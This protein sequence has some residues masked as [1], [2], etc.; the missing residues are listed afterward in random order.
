MFGNNIKLYAFKSLVSRYWLVFKGAWSVRDKLDPPK[1]N[2]DELAFLPAHLELVET[3]VSAAPKWT[4]RIIITFTVLALVWSI[5][6]QIDVVATGQGKIILS[7][8]S[9][10]IQSLE[11]AV[12][13]SLYVA[14][15]QQ[16]EQGEVLI[17]LAALGSDTDY[18]QAS[19]ALKAAYLTRWRST[20]LISSIKTREVPVHQEITDLFS[21]DINE[22]DIEQNLTLALNQFFSWRTKDHQLALL[23]EQKQAE[24]ETLKLEL[25]KTGNL[26]S[27][28]NKKLDNLYDLHKNSYISEHAYLEQR[29]IVINL[30]SDKETYLS[31][32]NEI[33]KSI[34]QTEEERQLNTQNLI[35]ESLDN[36]RQAN[37][38]IS[39]LASETSKAKQR[40]QL[41]KLV[42]PVDGTVQQLD[43][44]T[45]GGVVTTAQ[46]LMVVVPMQDKFEVE[47][48]IQNKDIGFIKPGQ[49][50]VIKIESFPYTRYGYIT[51]KVRS[52]SFDAI[53][54]PD[55]GLIF[56]AIVTL[57]KDHLKIE[58]NTVQLTAGMSV[59]VEINTD[60]RKIIDYLLSPLKTKID[61]SFKER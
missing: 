55:L 9:K 61:S 54:D 22:V 5:V 15:G 7:G 12:V 18:E 46:P 37:E 59:S 30:K 56:S 43:V 13:K 38:Q 33:K 32:I 17:E 27:I 48:M 29:S 23:V 35:T 1:R 39:Q 8:H 28:E 24:I 41:M 20:Q 50:A 2:S 58:N 19:Q 47:T 16:V 42:S 49:T 51:G 52:V 34:S 36:L 53:E 6:G 3:P 57:D 21:K 14:N 4:A 25:S 44:H 40:Q 45:I 11:N 60:K 10:T 31:K 26:F